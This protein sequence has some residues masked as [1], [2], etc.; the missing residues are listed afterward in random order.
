ML[1]HILGI[2]LTFLSFVMSSESMVFGG[3]VRHTSKSHECYNALKSFS[4]GFGSSPNTNPRPQLFFLPTWEFPVRI[5]ES[6][7]LRLHQGGNLNF[8]LPPLIQSLFFLCVGNASITQGFESL[9]E[10]R[11]TF[12]HHVLIMEQQGG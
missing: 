4:S 8:C 9:S 1:K 3:E 6:P 2:S 7:S 5:D 11:V 12:W 10:K